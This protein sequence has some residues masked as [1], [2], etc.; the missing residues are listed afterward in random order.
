MKRIW[1]EAPPSHGNKYWNSGTMKSRQARIQK[2]LGYG[3]IVVG[4]CSKCKN[5]NT[6]IMKEQ[7]DGAIIITRYCSDHLPEEHKTQIPM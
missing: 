1:N 5:L 2:L 6:H 7:I 4:L 3:N